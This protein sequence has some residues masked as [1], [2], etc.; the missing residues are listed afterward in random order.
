MRAFYGRR[1][2]MH[3]SAT[4]DVA[5]AAR[6]PGVRAVAVLADPNNAETATLRYAGAPIAAVAAIDAG[7]S[8]KR[9]SASSRSTAKRCPSSSI[10]TKR[11]SP[12]RRRSTATAAYAQ[13]SRT[14]GRC[15][16]CRETAT[17]NRSSRPEIAATCESG[18]AAGRPRRERRVPHVRPDA[19]LPRTARDRRR[20]ARD[21]LTVYV[22]TQFTAG[23]RATLAREFGLPMNRVRVI[24]AAMGGG[25]GS[26]SS[27][28]EYGRIAVR[29][30]RQA[31]APVRSFSTAK[32]NNSIPVIGREPGNGCA[33]GA[34]RDGSLTAIV[35]RATVRRVSEPEPAWATSRR[36][37]TPARTSRRAVRRLHQRRDRAR[38]CAD[39]GI[40]QARS[41]SNKPIDELAERLR[42][43]PAD[44]TRRHRP[45]RGSARRTPASERSASDGVGGTRRARTPGASGAVSAS[46]SRSG[47]RTSRP[48]PG[49]RSGSYRD[50]SVE[51]LSSVQDIGTGIGTI[52]AQVVAEE[53]GLRPAADRRAHR[54]YRLSRR[55][56]VVRESNDRVDH[57][58]GTHCSISGP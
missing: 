12:A 13:R 46:R 42:A 16:T 11:V 49:A 40:R 37:S 4:I 29:L 39:R 6:H 20:L 28:R 43:R 55:T 8:P 31:D 58:A 22:S 48:M 41:L 24:V 1:C 32:R 10:S 44:I 34:R 47:R 50:G 38:R 3:E 27:L 7:R 36:L 17:C 9:R 5:A 23:V 25:F 51:I 14:N 52:L 2:R 26:K 56:A 54:R 53:L 57:A 15:R 18:F 19:L 33:I 21:G 30:S 35:A 45:E